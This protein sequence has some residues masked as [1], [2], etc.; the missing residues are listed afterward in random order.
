MIPLQYH[1]IVFQMAKRGSV[2]IQINKVLRSARLNNFVG[3]TGK[4]INLIMS[5][6]GRWIEK[7]TVRFFTEGYGSKSIVTFPVNHITLVYPIRKSTYRT[8]A[9]YAREHPEDDRVDNI[10]DV[11]EDSLDD[12]VDDVD[13]GACVSWVEE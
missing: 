11:T 8:Y 3:R 1:S 4:I 5:E 6:C 7:V 12:D 13:D 9:D 10:I 2:D